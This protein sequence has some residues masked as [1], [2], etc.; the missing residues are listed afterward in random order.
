MVV[1]TRRRSKVAKEEASRGAGAKSSHAVAQG[2]IRRS[3]RLQR[4]G[5]AGPSLSTEQN[6]PARMR[7]SRKRAPQHPLPNRAPKRKK[8]AAKEKKSNGRSQV[9]NVEKPTPTKADRL[10]VE[11]FFSK[12]KGAV[13]PEKRFLAWEKQ[14]K[15]LLRKK[16]GREAAYAHDTFLK[17]VLEGGV[18]PRQ[19]ICFSVEECLEA[20]RNYVASLRELYPDLILDPYIFDEDKLKGYEKDWKS[21]E[22]MEFF[23]LVNRRFIVWRPSDKKRGNW[24]NTME[25]VWGRLYDSMASTSYGAVEANSEE[26]T[27]MSCLI[28]RTKFKNGR[29]VKEPVEDSATLG[30]IMT[31][32]CTASNTG[33]LYFTDG[34]LP[35]Y[36]EKKMSI[37]EPGLSC[38][39][40]DGAN[41][42]LPLML[43]SDR[44]ESLLKFMKVESTGTSTFTFFLPLGGGANITAFHFE[45]K[46]LRSLNCGT[47]DLIFQPLA[48]EENLRKLDRI[49]QAI[50]GTFERH[51]QLLPIE[52]YLEEGIEMVT[53]LRDQGYAECV[54]LPILSSH[55]FISHGT[56]FSSPP[57][58]KVSCNDIGLR[59]EPLTAY[60][61]EEI[62][63]NEKED[64]L[65]GEK[66]RQADSWMESVYLVNCDFNPASKSP[67]SGEISGQRKCEYP[68]SERDNRSQDMQTCVVRLAERLL[69]LVDERLKRNV[70]K[71]GPNKEQAT[72][73]LK[74]LL[75]ALQDVLNGL[76][77]GPGSSGV[78][79]REGVIYIQKLIER[80]E[81]LV[82]VDTPLLHLLKNDG[83]QRMEFIEGCVARGTIL[84]EGE[85]VDSLQGAS[86]LW[87]MALLMHSE[88]LKQGRGDL[89]L[90]VRR[91]RKAAENILENVCSDWAA[92]ECDQ[93]ASG[94]G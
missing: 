65:G 36:S 12:T 6:R 32:V 26:A 9:P 2:T 40:N 34:T 52:M 67:W 84:P 90:E 39:V 77:E 64:M 50:F 13:D 54:E 76:R 44:P 75:P 1:M 82:E 63:K 41:S 66:Q 37:D 80:V 14:I 73:G 29:V 28:T 86:D 69:D 46:R 68:G 88:A 85:Q 92:M 55:A 35:N 42:M 78:G 31:D 18:G 62:A 79:N 43:R 15:L 22:D 60:F 93:E 72:E 71:G 47:G 56:L 3:A 17:R 59:K 30:S 58:Y 48:T 87:S 20:S 19:R 16:G 4:G 10:K 8:D 70:V 5:D 21:T 89:L 57:P 51:G 94:R 91:L 61:L 7:A 25:Q 53:Y 83:Q 45:T 33:K 23:K 27:E 38:A 49:H 24:D 81:A 11:E 74:T